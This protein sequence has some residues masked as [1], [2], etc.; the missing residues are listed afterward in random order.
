MI[1]SFDE[2]NSLVDMLQRG[3]REPLLQV[4]MHT[5]LQL[6][7]RSD[8]QGQALFL[9]QMDVVM[10]AAS[11]TLVRKVIP[12]APDLVLHIASEVYDT[13]GH[14]R[15]IE[16]VVRAL[17]ERR[18][19]LILTDASGHYRNGRLVLGQLEKRFQDVGLEVIILQ[20][21]SLAGRAAELALR[22]A[23][24]APGAILLFAHHFDSIANAAVSGESAPRVLYIHHA[25]HLPALGATRKDLVHIDLA[26]ACHTAC[27]T[28]YPFPHTFLG[29][30]M[31]DRGTIPFSQAT[32]LV[33][34][35]CGSHTKYSGCCEFTYGQL[36]GTFF[37][38]GIAHLLHIGSMPQSQQEMIHEEIRAA[39][40]DAGKLTFIPN[41]PSLA[42]A[43]KTIGPAFYLGSHP[44][45][46][47]KAVVEALSVGLPTVFVGPASTLPLLCSD[48]ALDASLVVR[49]LSDVP[50]VVQRLQTERE[51]LGA[52]SRRVFDENYAP[53]VFRQ[54]LVDVLHVPG[55]H[56]VL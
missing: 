56:G 7:H 10:Q 25:D 50:G 23:H 22:I 43:L 11:R 17:P 6:L 41:V 37:A 2:M 54:K 1:V 8:L 20:E 26:T 31:A 35:T 38:S 48:M 34:V 13:G 21:G 16:D 53:Q 44:V 52:A 24:S 47:G 18:H 49:R 4:V 55:L 28:A 32:P 9:P 15:V 27:T 3:E 46:G 5:T 51:A 33:G 12:T 36:L 45:A 29:M 42:E 39:G 14:T 40:Q 30:S 19:Q